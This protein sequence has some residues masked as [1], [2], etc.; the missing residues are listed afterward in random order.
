MTDALQVTPDELRSI[1]LLRGFTDEQL[2]KIVALF[3]RTDAAA[4]VLFNPGEQADSFYLLTEGSVTLHAPGDEEY[5]LHPVAVIGELGALTSRGRN[6]KA[7]VASGSVVWSIAVNRLLELFDTDK[8]IGLGFQL[9]LMHVVAE[10]IE[11]DQRRLQ[12]MRE[13]IIR[14]QKAMKRM[15]DLLL[16]SQDTVI[17]ESL[18]NTI[19][20][21][22]KKNRRVNYRVAPPFALPAAVRFDDGTE[23]PVAEISRTHVAF[24]LD[25]KTPLADANRISAVLH[26][27]GPEIPMTG[28]VVRA[29]DDR[30]VVELDL[31]VDEYAAALEGYLTRV[32][33][34]DFLV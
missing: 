3:E 8:S 16:E 28:K 30:V 17:S 31:L 5:T 1:P 6:S 24:R 25:A 27:S 33:M 15:R 7:V 11:R 14:T 29:L 21:L 34:L 23:V 9:N 12:D 22:I 13:N 32:Q 10:K 26:M 4:E 19:E 20:D 2:G 18:H